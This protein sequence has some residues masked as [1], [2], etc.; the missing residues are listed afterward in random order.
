MFMMVAQ[1]RGFFSF[2]ASLEQILAF[3][4]MNPNLMP[5]NLVLGGFRLA[6]S[7]LAEGR[8][9]SAYGCSCLHVQTSWRKCPSLRGCPDSGVDLYKA[10]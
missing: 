4:L 1:L 9:V 2:I 3:E 5:S 7:G 8:T 10:Q 6:L